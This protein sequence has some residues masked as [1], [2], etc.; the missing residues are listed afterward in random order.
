[1]SDIDVNLFR[2]GDYEKIRIGEDDVDFV[3]DFLDTRLGEIRPQIVNV[4]F[5]K[6]L[7]KVKWTDGSTTTVECAES[8]TFDEEKGILLC[9]AKKYYGNSDGFYEKISKHIPKK[10]TEA[11]KEEKEVKTLSREELKELLGLLF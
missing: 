11:V 4:K 6:P 7:T 10:K 9:I 1:M 8:D 3:R 5:M 2:S